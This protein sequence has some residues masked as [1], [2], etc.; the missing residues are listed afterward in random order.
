[1]D[2]AL[3]LLASEQG[4]MTSTAIASGAWYLPKNLRSVLDA[5]ISSTAGIIL[6]TIVAMV[7]AS[8]V[9][10]FLPSGGRAGLTGIIAASAVYYATTKFVWLPEDPL[11]PLD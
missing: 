10:G 6:P 2:T 7:G 8:I 5:P 3:A 1:M 9:G 11:D 4:L